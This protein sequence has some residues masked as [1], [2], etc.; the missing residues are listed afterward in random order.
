MRFSDLVP[1]YG[2]RTRLGAKSLSSVYKEYSAVVEKISEKCRSEK[3]FLR[4]VFGEV[5][6]TE[7][8]TK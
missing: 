2:A 7:E 5:M 6:A 4:K 3:L 1:N 8:K